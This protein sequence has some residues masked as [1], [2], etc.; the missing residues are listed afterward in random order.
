M[1]QVHSPDNINYSP[2][3]HYLS[4]LKYYTYWKAVAFGMV[5]TSSGWSKVDA[6]IL[7]SRV[8]DI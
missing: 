6:D 2:L 4:F 5:G 8:A 3:G 7:E 1:S